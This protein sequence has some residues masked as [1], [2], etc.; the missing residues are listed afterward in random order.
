MK[1]KLSPLVQQKILKLNK[2]DKRLVI[3]IRKQIELFELNPRHPSL[4]IHKLTGNLSNMWSISINR[5]V[6]MVYI[7]LEENIA[8]FVDIGTHDQVYRK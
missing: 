3:K 2:K 7:I 5:D 1:S 4:R 8:Y 6:R